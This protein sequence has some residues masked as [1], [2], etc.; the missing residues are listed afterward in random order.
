MVKLRLTR[1]G[2]KK[3]PFYRVVAMEALTRRDGKPIAYLGTYNPLTDN[4]ESIKLDEAEVLKFLG[5][6]AQPTQTVRSLLK[7][8]G[9]WAKFEE[10]KKK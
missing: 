9:I 7:K 10:S 1:I 5:N 6:G 4:E 2:R 3:I 8:V